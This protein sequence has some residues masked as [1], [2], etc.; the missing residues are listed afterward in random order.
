MSK[1]ETD[2]QTRIRLYLSHRMDLRLFRNNVGCLPDGH[3]GYIR[4]GL[5]TGSGDLIGIKQVNLTCHCGAIIPAGVF[6]SMEVKRIKDTSSKEQRS[7]REMVSGL[8]GIAGVV[9]SEEEAEKLIETR[10]W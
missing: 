7:F 5:C 9:R 8:N 1:Q 6:V 3:G 10:I 4:F 2:L